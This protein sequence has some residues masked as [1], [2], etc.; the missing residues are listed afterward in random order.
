M[1]H[2]IVAHTITPNKGEKEEQHDRAGLYT[3]KDPRNMPDFALKG[4][5]C[6]VGPRYCGD[7]NMCAYGKEY[8]R[9]LNM[10]IDGIT[11]LQ[12]TEKY[13]ANG[14]DVAAVVGRTKPIGVIKTGG[15]GHPTHI[16]NEQTAVHALAGLWRRRASHYREK[17]QELE[18]KARDAERKAAGL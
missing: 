7:C 4:H 15:S 6:D 17:A 1:M 11:R 3:V 14:A 12:L 10:D 13:G 8:L 2:V 9:R 16:Y 18:D 5:L